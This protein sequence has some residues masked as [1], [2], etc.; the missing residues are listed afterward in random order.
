MK[1]LVLLNGAAGTLAGAA[2]DDQ[3]VIIRDGFVRHGHECE[4]R[5]VDGIELFDTSRRSAQSGSH[6]LIVAGGGDGTLNTV[7]SALVGTGVAFAVLPLGTFNHFAKELQ[8]PLDLTEA[9]EALATGETIPFSIGKVNHKYFLLFCAVGLYT[10]MVRHRDAQREVLGRKKMWAGFIAFV[11]MLAR[12]P[13]MRLRLTGIE[14]P[15]HPDL[16]RLTTTAYVSLSGYQMQQMGLNDVPENSRDALTL[17]ISPHVTRWQLLGFL[18]KAMF[19]RANSR[20]DLERLRA[21]RL[22][23]NIRRREVVRVGYD[24]E[25]ESMKTPLRIERIENALNMRVPSAY[26]DRKTSSANFNEVAS[27]AVV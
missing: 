6:S 18:F 24:G 7:A 27:T 9:V 25:V 14:G 10:D 22:E 15:S 17:L 13:L 21:Q 16:S 2:T 11:K 19:R 23:L 8:I 1:V 5:R 12:W 26:V 4:V 3:D 20:R